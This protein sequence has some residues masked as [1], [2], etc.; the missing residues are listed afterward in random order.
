MQSLALSSEGNKYVNE[1]EPWKVFAEN[2]RRANDICYNGL[3]L[4]KA[5]TVFASPFLPHT[6]EKV[7]KQL[8]L[9]G[10]PAEIGAWENALKD[11]GKEHE[12]GEPELLFTKLEVKDIEKIKAIVSDGVDLKE[13]FKK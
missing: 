7:W 3:L 12:I 8:N 5:V 6:A 9:K 11:F 2:P 1:M 4:L 10:S 13:L